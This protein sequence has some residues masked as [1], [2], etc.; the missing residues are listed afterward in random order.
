MKADMKFSLAIAIGTGFILSIGMAFF[1]GVRCLVFLIL[2]NFCSS[3][4]RSFLLV[5]AMVLVMN[6]PVKNFSH[7]MDVMTEAA[8]CGASLAMNET[9]ELLETAA[10]PLMFVIRGVK[11]M[12]HAIKIFANEMQKAFMVLLRA[13]REI[14]AMIGRLFRWL[15]GMVDICNDRMGQPYRRCKRAFDN[16]FDKCVDV[17]W[18]F[19]FICY[20]VKAVA[21]V[22]NI[23]RIG[24]LLCLIVSAIRS[25]VLEQ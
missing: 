8:T 12:L 9:K 15:Y 18:I 25:L 10:A 2:P 21:L 22:C 13:V 1:K 6:F 4:G 11:K 23:A 3:K 16:A 7:N 24:E 14:M 20:I 19:A 17:M 5:Y